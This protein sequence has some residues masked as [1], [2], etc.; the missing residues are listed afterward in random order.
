[1]KAFVDEVRYR[2]HRGGGT[3]VVMTKKLARSGGARTPQA[4]RD[5]DAGAGAP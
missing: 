3:E 4:P 1:M 2:R 5:D